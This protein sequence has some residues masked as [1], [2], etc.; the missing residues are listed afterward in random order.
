MTRWETVDEEGI[1]ELSAGQIRE[2][3]RIMTEE[4][5]VD[6]LQMME[7]AGSHLARLTT[8][9]MG[10]DLREGPVVVLSGG[11]NNG[12][13]GM[14]AARHLHNRGIGVSV[15]TIGEP[16]R[17]KPAPSHQRHTLLA[18]GIPVDRLE[19]VGP[20]ELAARLGGAACLLDAVVGYGLVGSPEGAVLRAIEVMNRAE[21]PVLSLDIPSGFDTSEGH[22]RETCVRAL[23]TLA[24]TLPKTGLFSVAGR[25]VAGRLFLC[26]IGVPG[27]LYRRVGADPGILFGKGRILELKKYTPGPECSA[28]DPEGRTKRRMVLPG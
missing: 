6:L 11:G 20:A 17:M 1:P 12:G 19:S 28:R 18:M 7:L 2:V 14:A 5:G 13:G 22:L 25:K 3:D 26:D 23:A 8:G 27:S 15:L 16:E 10:D 4:L 24:L 9:F 21:R